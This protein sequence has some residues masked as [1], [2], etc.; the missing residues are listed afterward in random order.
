MQNNQIL[1][2]TAATTKHPFI[3]ECLRDF[4]LPAPNSHKG[5]NGKL[6]LIGGSELF[7]AASKWSLDVASRIVDMV[8][9]A[10]TPENNA[11]ISEAKGQFWNGIVV[12]QSE[13][14]SYIAEADCILIGPGMQRTQETKDMVDFLL[15]KYAHKKWVIDAGALQMVDPALLA[16]QHIIT[17]HHKEMELLRSKLLGEPLRCSVLLK[18]STDVITIVDA[19]NSATTFQVTGGNAGMTKGGT[20][21]VLAGL[22]AALYTTQTAKASCFLASY[23]NKKTADELYKTV[24][25]FFNASDLVHRIP[26]VL[27]AVVEV[28]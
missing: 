18:G 26:K 8:F 25:P 17:P 1:I 27:A 20:G 15:K 23:V 22:L 13:I 12:P 21:D 28:W 2:E 19:D 7:H 6:L 14:E 5:D 11:L 16:P 3:S 24:G 10:S 4:R 9:Y